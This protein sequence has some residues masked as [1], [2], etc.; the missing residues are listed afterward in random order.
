MSKQPPDKYK[1]LKLRNNCVLK[2]I[3]K[4]NRLVADNQ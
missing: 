3:Y 2:I 4:L 1:C